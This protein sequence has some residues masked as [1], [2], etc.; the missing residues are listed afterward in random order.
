MAFTVYDSRVWGDVRGHELGSCG[1]NREVCKDQNAGIA[2]LRALLATEILFGTGTKHVA[3]SG[4]ISEVCTR[5]ASVAMTACVCEVLGP[6][7]RPM[8]RVLGGS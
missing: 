4:V 5:W 2:N 1:I 7:C 3:A 8:P 6:Y